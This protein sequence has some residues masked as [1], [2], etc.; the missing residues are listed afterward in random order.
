VMVR[1]EMARLLRVSEE[2]MGGTRGVLQQLR[3]T[4]PA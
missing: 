3:E 1:E 4:L 2:R